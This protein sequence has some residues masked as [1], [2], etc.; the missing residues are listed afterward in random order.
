MKLNKLS[1]LLK[2]SIF[3]IL[4]FFI[5]RYVYNNAVVMNTFEDEIN[6]LASNFNFFTTLNFDARPLIPLNYGVGLTSGPLSAIGGV[7]GWG[8]SKNILIARISNFYY[9]YFLQVLFSYFIAK[10]F[11]L[12]IYNL[13]LFSGVQI[14]LVPWWIGSLYSMG[15]VA[16]TIIFANSM[17]LFSKNRKISIILFSSSIIYGKFLLMVPFVAFYVG[18]LI[19]NLHKKSKFKKTL[20]DIGLF[21]VPFLFWYLLIIFKTGIDNFIVYINEFVQFI[22]VFENS[23]F[24]SARKISWELI[25]QQVNESE[26]AVWSEASILRILIAPLIFGVIVYRNRKE[27]NAT[28]NINFIP[29]LFSVYSTYA[30]FWGLSPLKYMRHTKHFTLI[31][32]FFLFYFLVAK[33]TKNNFD[34]LLIFSLI[35]I[36]FS[37]MF[38]IVI[39]NL[40]IYLLYFLHL[41]PITKNKIMNTLFIIFLITNLVVGINEATLKEP[42][43]LDFPNCNEGLTVE[44][45]Y[46]DYMYYDIYTGKKK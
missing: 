37:D 42:V 31:I 6:S 10:K 38:L 23:G 25:L 43:N 14:L 27:I 9:V 12:N 39:S 13:V 3:L 26:V 15:E 46:A 21:I 29:I 40:I 18:N 44:K 5:F 2:V 1:K 34:K 41:T 33:S 20:V 36:Y 35:T 28:L 11:K 8:I 30:W 45:C 17:I 32:I 4:N 22:Y 7:I 19:I 24:E 16:S